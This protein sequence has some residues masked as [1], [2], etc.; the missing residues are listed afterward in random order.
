MVLP[1]RFVVP[2]G[3]HLASKEQ[4]WWWPGNQI[5]LYS[6]I[7]THKIGLSTSAD[8]SKAPPRISMIVNKTWLPYLLPTSPLLLQCSGI[9]AHRSTW[10]IYLDSELLYV[11]RLVSFLAGLG[12]KPSVLYPNGPKIS[13]N[14]ISKVDNRN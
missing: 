13:L 1:I 11:G 5:P 2:A 14:W 4:R 6:Q 12:Q 8:R 7:N 9:Y 10:C 3:H